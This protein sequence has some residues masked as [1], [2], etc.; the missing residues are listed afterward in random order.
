VLTHSLDTLTADPALV[1]K[2]RRLCIQPV[3]CNRYRQWLR[4]RTGGEE[5]SSA[6]KTAGT[7]RLRPKLRYL[8]YNKSTTTNQQPKR[9][10]L[11]FDLDSDL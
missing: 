11:T 1:I 10:L 7:S 3:V 5:L 9:P 4:L 8:L 2:S 6:A